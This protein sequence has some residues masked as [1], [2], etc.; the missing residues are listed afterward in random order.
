MR[1]PPN[2]YC[3]SLKQPFYILVFGLDQELTLLICRNIGEVNPAYLQT[4]GKPRRA[5]HSYGAETWPGS[6]LGF[7]ESLAEDLRK[8]DSGLCHWK[9]CRASRSHRALLRV[10]PLPCSDWNRGFR[11]LSWTCGSFEA[12]LGP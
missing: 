3:L 8:S 4:L 12:Y 2:S 11:S 1:E 6:I 10:L 9:R 5:L 7:L